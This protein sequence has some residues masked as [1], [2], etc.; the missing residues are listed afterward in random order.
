MKDSHVN[1]PPV[2]PVWPRL[3]LAAALAF[4]TVPFAAAPAQAADDITS[5]VRAGEDVVLD[6]DAV[7]RLGDGE[8]IVYGGRFSGT[9]TLTVSGAGKLVLTADS[10]FAYPGS[11]QTVEVVGQPWA[12]SRI[13]DADPPAVTVEAG[14]TLQYGDGTGSTGLIGHYP[15]DTPD[16]AWNSLNH[17]ID[18]TL[19]VAV[20]GPRYHPGVLSG[21]GYLVQPRFT[22]DGLAL[23]GDHTFTGTIYNGT[24]IHFSDRAYQSQLPDVE[25]I[26]NQGSFIV[27]NQRENETVLGMDFYSREW[28]NDINFH[29]ALDGTKVVM[30]GVY[31]WADSGPDSDPS[32]SD[33]ALNYEVVAHNHNKRGINIEGATVQWGDGTTDRFF[34]PGNRDTVYINLHG[35]NHDQ[36][37]HLIF[38]YNGPVELGAPISGGRYH[39]TM[40]APGWGDVTIAGTPGNDVTFADQQNYDGATTIEAEA[41]LRLGTGE[42][43]GDA[44]LL[45]GGERTEIIDEGALVVDN[46]DTEV[47]LE[48]VHGGG[49]LEQAGSATLRLTGG[50]DY[51]GATIVSDGTLA[52]T[53][54]DIAASDRVDLTGDG[55][56]LDL[57]QVGDQTVA[58]LSG[59][60]G[61]AVKL[62]T[63]ALT[64]ASAEDTAYAGAFEGEGGLVKSGPGTWTFAGASAATGAW[65]VAEGALTLDNAGLA[66]ALDVTTG[67]TVTGPSTIA[68]NL[69]L[70]DTAVLT[71]GTGTGAEDG[72]DTSAG[73]DGDSGA[74]ASSDAGSDTDAG[75][76][77]STDSDSDASAS[78]GGGLAVDGEAVLGG[79]LAVAVE[80]GAALPEE[81]TV[82]TAAGGLTGTFDGLAEGAELDVA[83]T[84][85]TV[86]YENSAVVL[87]TDSPR[88]AEEAS[89]TGADAI[90]PLPLWVYVS[91]SLIVL[92][93]IGLGLLFWFRRRRR[94][95]A[96]ND[97]TLE[98]PMVRP[99]T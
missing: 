90:G 61:A 21:S 31:S 34:L 63:E 37:G 20:H 79:T 16:F 87:R 4:L 18:G 24:G 60:A 26:L 52:L 66:G 72:S 1:G 67:L 6:G 98:L 57:S 86:S 85:Y 73:A 97:A 12:W 10:D 53:G 88:E 7:V 96:S 38:D 80:E 36:R 64:V 47:E 15:Y 92:L 30:T 48:D 28:G 81:I 91:A 5:R 22:W 83:G 76:G 11:S 41:V 2:R 45:V 49:S 8:E 78:A 50:T 17:R 25:K 68:G 13:E 65:S 84:A 23:A 94:G 44:W 43:G 95:G 70:G 32:L 35:A 74:D 29:S 62:G 71:V 9:G 27:N 3:L 99:G 93:L 55:A 54:G 19:I 77:T 59:V 46:T 40:A 82:L 58:D 89:A 69:S 75:S 51:T 33:P 42:D 14:A 56:V 39:D